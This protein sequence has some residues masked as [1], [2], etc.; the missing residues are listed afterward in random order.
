MGARLSERT[1]WQMHGE[2][3]THGNK[4]PNIAQHALCPSRKIKRVPGCRQPAQGLCRTIGSMTLILLA[5]A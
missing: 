5:F 1:L 2:S 3:A 4:V